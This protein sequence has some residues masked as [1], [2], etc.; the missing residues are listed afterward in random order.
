MIETLADR[1]KRFVVDAANP[2]VG[3]ATFKDLI[4]RGGVE[5]VAALK[6]G[7]AGLEELKAKRG[8][9]QGIIVRVSH[10]APPVSARSDHRT[11]IRRQ[12]HN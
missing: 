7:S 12:T 4:G 10:S 8:L 3:L 1:Y 6:E 9:P 11:N 2:G 5:L